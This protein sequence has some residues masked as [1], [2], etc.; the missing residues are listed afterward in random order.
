MLSALEFVEA[1]GRC[2]PLASDASRRD[3]A[4]VLSRVPHDAVSRVGF[5]R[6]LNASDDRIDY[7]LGFSDADADGLRQTATGLSHESSPAEAEVLNGL[8]TFADR[9]ERSERLAEDIRCLWLEYDGDGIAAGRRPPGVFLDSGPFPPPDRDAHEWM[10]D[11]RRNIEM[12]SGH[13]VPASVAREVDRCL[14]ACPPG[15]H[16]GTVGFF[17]GRPHPGLRL[18]LAGFDLWGAMKFLSQV[19]Y[20]GDVDRCL[21][22][23]LAVRSGASGILEEI[24]MIHLDVMPEGVGSRVGVELVFE[25]NR[26]VSEHHLA[27]DVLD[28]LVREGLADPVRCR[29]LASW[30]GAARREGVDPTVY[31]RRVNHL[32]IVFEGHELTE[33][34][35]Y[36]GIRKGLP[37]FV[38][39][40]SVGQFD[41]ELR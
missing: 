1:V 18:C 7:F 24:G 27:T 28:A 15:V 25:V 2:G 32:K 13:R 29:E 30:P 38:P 10:S 14:E 31:L 17:L 26:Q 11:R 21:T 22:S 6:R 41:D 8:H 39:P 37:R 16:P 40:D 4:L 5:E 12:I 33:A 20:D 19:G 9:W 23:V 36:F 34:K 35:A 3:L